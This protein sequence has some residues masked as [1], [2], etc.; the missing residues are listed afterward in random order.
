MKH[1]LHNIS[2]GNAPPGEKV[3]PFR[4]DQFCCHFDGGTMEKSVSAE[5]KSNRFLTAFG[6]ASTGG[7][8]LLN[9]RDGPRGR[10]PATRFAP[11]N[12]LV[13][14]IKK[15]SVNL[16]VHSV[17]SVVKER[18]NHKEHREATENAAVNALNPT[19]A[20]RT[21][22]TEVV[23]LQEENASV[24]MVEYWSIGRLEY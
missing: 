22:C 10:A 16:C 20:F 14:L 2:K 17:S 6:M 7:Q 3:N 13:T 12:G 21:N 11:V 4:V 18:I 5:Q 1:N 19:K 9:M 24:G 15:S 8:L 23:R